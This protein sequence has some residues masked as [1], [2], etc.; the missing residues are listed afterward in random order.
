MTSESIDH[1]LPNCNSHNKYI[2]I[3]F[4]LYTIISCLVWF[5]YPWIKFMKR[6]ER[7][8]TNNFG[9]EYFAPVKH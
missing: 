9:S 1:D 3:L 7:T 2:R 8:D 6:F 5:K 4:S